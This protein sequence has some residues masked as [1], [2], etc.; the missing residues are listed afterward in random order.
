MLKQNVFLFL[1]QSS[2]TLLSLAEQ[3]PT[4]SPLINPGPLINPAPK[5]PHKAV[6]LRVSA[7]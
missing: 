7:A 5:K 6:R 1:N 3:T 2:V 4:V